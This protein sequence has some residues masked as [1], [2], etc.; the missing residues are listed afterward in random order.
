MF[1]V[2]DISYKYIGKSVHIHKCCNAGSLAGLSN[3][4]SWSCPGLGSS[5]LTLWPSKHWSEMRDEEKK[6]EKWPCEP[7]GENRKRARK[8]LAARFIWSIPVPWRGA[9]TRAGKHRPGAAEQQITPPFSI[10]LC[11]SDKR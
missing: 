1:K 2:K 11:C 10:L 3:H 6:G 8:I 5:L 9:H 7:Q 4:T